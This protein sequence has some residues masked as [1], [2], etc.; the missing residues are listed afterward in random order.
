MN[1]VEKLRALLPHWME[2]NQEHAGEFE[3]WAEKATAAGYAAAAQTI[4]R[5]AEAMQQV[6]AALQSALDEL[7][8]PV[9]LEH[10]HHSH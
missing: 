10:H 6:N 3:A 7:G 8:G 9:H 2:H 1:D 5:A 4:R